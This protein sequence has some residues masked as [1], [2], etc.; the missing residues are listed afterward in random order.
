MRANIPKQ[1]PRKPGM[2]LEGVYLQAMREISSRLMEALPE[3]DELWQTLGQ[4]EAMLLEAQMRDMPLSELLGNGGAEAFCRSIVDE[5]RACG[6]MALPAA[7][8]GFPRPDRQAKEQRDGP[9]HKSSRWTSVITAAVMVL[10]F[11]VLALWYTGILRYWSRGTSYYLE[12]LHNFRS[13]V[14]EV[15]SPP[16]T[17]TLPLETV[18]GRGDVL[19]S[20]GEGY[21]VILTSVEKHTYKGSFTDP[22]TGETTYGV[23]T[24]WYLRMT[25][26]VESDFRHISYVEPASD[27]DVT[28]TLPNGSVYTGEI[29]WIESGEA[30]PGR[31]FARISVIAF[32]VG[33]DTKGATLTVTMDPP[34]RVEWTRTSMGAR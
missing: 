5:Y 13:E 21:D 17:V 25:Y 2:E 24:S 26:A 27:G 20:D 34:Q 19:Y 7:V 4:T 30:E 10:I 8:N 29:T 18:T 31:E 28:V 16:I 14:T 3:G 9:R 11:A 22:E 15:E 6:E 33:M 23:M 32:P 1:P 12:E